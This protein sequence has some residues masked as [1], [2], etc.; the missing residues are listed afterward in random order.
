MD[1]L[2]QL[3]DQRET[4]VIVATHDPLIASRCD[5]I[6]RLRDG[7]ATDQITVTKTESADK[8]LERIRR[9]RP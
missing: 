1:L 4:T 8:T 3:R 5:S 6:V 2:V 9:F 7:Q